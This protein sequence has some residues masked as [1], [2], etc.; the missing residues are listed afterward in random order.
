MLKLTQTEYDF[1]VLLRSAL[2]NGIAKKEELSP[3]PDASGILRLA[4]NHKLRHMILSA[5]PTE[6]IPETVDRRIELFSRVSAQVGTTS[7]FLELWS[8][9]EKAGFHPIVVKG[10]ICRSLY[11]HPELRPSSDEDLYISESEFEDCCKFLQS[12]GLIPDKNDFSEHGEI[13]W[14]GKNGVCLELHR[15]LFEGGALNILQKFFT[16][17]SIKKKTYPTHYGTSVVSMEPHDHFLYLLLHSYKHF[18][19]SGVGIRQICDIGIWAQ[20][21]NDRINWKELSVQCESAGIKSFAA[22]VFGIARLQLN[23]PFRLPEDFERPLEYC[24]PLLK[25][26]LCGGIYGTADADRL[27]S[28]TMTLNAV[29][30]S[31]TNKNPSLFRSVFPSR[32]DLIGRYPYLKSHPALLP[33]AWCSRILSYAQSCLSGQSNASESIAIGKERIDLLR[34]Y[35]IIQ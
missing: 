22:A 14:K 13:G 30:A 15:D 34:F 35:N 28:A 6:L 33:V 17:D 3:N 31:K 9:M 26:I 4:Y 23:I 19:H 25:D 12:Q 5:F 24:L 1:L 7:A 21:Y 27:H 16:F 18:I 11:H 10:I 8:S 2:A 29:N 32:N 20:K